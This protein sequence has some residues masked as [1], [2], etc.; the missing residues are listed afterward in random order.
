[1]LFQNHFNMFLYTS[2]CSMI[3]FNALKHKGCSPIIFLL[4][5]LEKIILYINGN[6]GILIKTNIFNRYKNVVVKTLNLY[7]YSEIIL[8][9]S[10]PF[11]TRI[12]YKLPSS[13]ISL[14]FVFN[15]F[16]NPISFFLTGIPTVPHASGV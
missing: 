8:S 4:G 6:G 9:L 12:A 7:H 10:S 14:I 2:L 16:N 13:F 3:P 11:S 15:A 1:M 5:N